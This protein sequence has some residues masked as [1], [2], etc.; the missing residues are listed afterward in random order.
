[1]NT[2]RER[3]RAARGLGHTWAR[4]AEAE[5]LDTATDIEAAG[6]IAIAGAC[7]G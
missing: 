2:Q 3:E 5:A 6:A 1:M 7:A 4:A